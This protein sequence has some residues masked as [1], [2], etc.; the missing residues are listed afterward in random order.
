MLSDKS[1]NTPEFNRKV[2]KRRDK[3]KTAA[4]SRKTNRKK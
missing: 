3:S 4:K 1:Q 2:K